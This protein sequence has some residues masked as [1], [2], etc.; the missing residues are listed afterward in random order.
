MFV[1]KSTSSP[2]TYGVRWAPR[3]SLATNTCRPTACTGIAAEPAP[4]VHC[5]IYT[6]S[7]KERDNVMRMAFAV[8]PVLSA[9]QLHDFPF[10]D[11]KEDPQIEEEQGSIHTQPCP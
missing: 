10:V 9:K 8:L 3:G 6:F 1:N 11:C 7:A 2:H 5:W 4:N